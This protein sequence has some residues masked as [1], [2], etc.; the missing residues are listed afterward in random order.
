MKLEFKQRTV[1]VDKAK[2]LY[3][4]DQIL[5][6][7][8]VGVALF[9]SA[10]R[11]NWWPAWAAI[12]IW[13]VFFI[14]MDLFLRFKTELIAER[15]SPPKGAKTWDR[16]ILSFLR[17]LQLARYILA[18]LDLR[19]GWTE[20][21]PITVQI[22]AIFLCLLGYALLIWAMISNNFFSQVMRIQSDRGHTVATSGPYRFVRHPAYVGMILFEIA[23]SILLDSW[24]SLLAGGV[25]VL[26]IVLRT[27][28]EDRTL[29][30]ELTAYDLYSRQVRFRLIPGVW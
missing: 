19:F 4:I 15:L 22:L 28:L 13:V 30:K 9:W 3:V 23:M 10:G 12:A 2:T 26:L 27:A 29:K 24:W 7:V 16:T 14:A 11:L 25:C 6:V 1:M 8:G 20:G 17:L 18:G 21:F 5:S